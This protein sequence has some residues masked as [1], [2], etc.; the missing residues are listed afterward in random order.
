MV[1]INYKAIKSYILFI[2]FGQDFSM[3]VE[4]YLSGISIQSFE[5]LSKRK[6]YIEK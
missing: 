3:H 1:I 6:M 4:R 5:A 2:R